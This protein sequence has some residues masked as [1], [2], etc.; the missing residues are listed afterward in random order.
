MTILVTGATDGL[1]P[2]LSLEVTSLGGGDGEPMN[3]PSWYT[4]ACFSVA[5]FSASSLGDGGR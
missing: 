2:S 5:W 1:R 4:R 3:E